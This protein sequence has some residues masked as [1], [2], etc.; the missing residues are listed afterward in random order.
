MLNNNPI[1][2]AF[3]SSETLKKEFKRAFF[4]FF[5]SIVCVILVFDFLLVHHPDLASGLN[6]FFQ[7]VLTYSTNFVL[8]L[9]GFNTYIQ[10]PWLAIQGYP[11]IEFAPGCLG[12]RH[13]VMF[14]VYIITYMGK[15]WQK[16]AYI[17]LGSIILTFVNIIRAYI[18]ALGQYWDASKTDLVHD[19]A[20]PIL[21]YV[22]ILVLWIVWMNRWGSPTWNSKST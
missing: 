16:T 11:G 19:I 8:N 17:A 6:Y 13:I 9:T 14:G 3:F 22:T 5:W 21:M 1:L 12:F 2:K 20:S 7:S 18:I 4:S 10:V 15:L